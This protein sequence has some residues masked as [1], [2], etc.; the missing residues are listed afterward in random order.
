[1]T[2]SLF[3]QHL[4]NGISLGALYAL[5]AIGYTMV[6][7][8]LRLIN[9]AHG[10]IV[11]V[12]AYAAFYGAAI[13]ALPWWLAFPLAILLTAGLGMVIER[14]AYRPLRGVPRIQLFTSA[15]A[16]SFLLE[17]LG[18]VIFGGRP[19]AFP[20]PDF[21][22][23]PLHI[24]DVVII[25]YTPVAVAV[26]LLL[27]GGLLY[28]VYRTKVGMA[29][30]ALS[31]DIETTGLMGV[32]TDRVIMIA[33][34]IGSALA[35]AGGILLA[36]KFP[37]LNPLMGVGPGL[38]AFVAAVLG[39]IGNVTGAMIGGFLLGIT[40]IMIVAFFPELA[41]YRDAFAYTIL[42][43]LLLFRPTGIMGEV[44]PEKV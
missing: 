25:S 5:I 43:V 19:K 33:F 39:G 1:M 9:F 18:I 28:I 24:G 6:Y 12:A 34:A 4:A 13:Y 42:I 44:E 41:G 11:M 37:Q 7:G 20:R 3:F 14:T 10:D 27:F 8:I 21:L 23:K 16:V 17:N 35:A 15:V 29:M 40:E 32:S 2:V 22:D 31:K 30:R 26:A 38:K 36:I